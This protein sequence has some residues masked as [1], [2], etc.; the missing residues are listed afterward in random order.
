VNVQT[1]AFC[2]IATLTFTLAAAA[3]SLMGGCAPS[4]TFVL[5]Q[6]TPNTVHSGFTLKQLESLVKVDPGSQKDF[7]T[8]LTAK[9]KEKLGVGP[10]E[11]GDLVVQYE[12]AL[13]D[14]GTSATRIGRTIGNVIGSPLYGLGEGAVGVDVL[15]TRLDGTALGHIVTDGL[16]AGAFGNTASALDEAAGF[17]ASYT[18][19]NFQC[20]H[21][22]ELGIQKPV[23]ERVKVKGLRDEY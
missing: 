6:P 8:K 16:V 19:A 23:S 1:N 18:K 3:S 20:P 12:L 10:S 5:Q 13:F 21:R 4:R 11:R 9:L 15:Y 14:Q 22:D 2:R 17:I 7:E